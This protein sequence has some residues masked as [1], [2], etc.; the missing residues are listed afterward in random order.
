MRL[1]RVNRTAHPRA[2]RD[3]PPLTV[4]MG[5]STGTQ[6]LN[7]GVVDNRPYSIRLSD[8]AL[9]AAP[10][11]DAR[12]VYL[13]GQVVDV[14][15]TSTEPL[16]ATLRDAASGT[17]FLRDGDTTNNQPHYRM[18]VGMC[19]NGDIL[20]MSLINQGELLRLSPTLLVK[21]VGVGSFALKTV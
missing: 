21:T 3:V 7:L 8:N 15:L 17:I 16:Q 18:V 4:F 13:V 12:T 5:S 20:S 11:N 1:E 14:T 6:F 10:A 19:D 9:A 2:R